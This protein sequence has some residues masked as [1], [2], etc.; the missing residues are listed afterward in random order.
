[1]LTTVAEIFGKA[2]STVSVVIVILYMTELLRY[3]LSLKGYQKGFVYSIVTIFVLMTIPLEGR[4]ILVK[5]AIGFVVIIL[6]IVD[7]LY[8]DINEFDSKKNATDYKWIKAFELLL[9][10][11]FLGGLILLAAQY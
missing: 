4:W 8:F 9:T 10:I 7:L 3:R 6:N 2:L 5:I 1:M 11:V